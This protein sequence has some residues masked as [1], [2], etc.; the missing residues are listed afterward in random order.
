MT[1][2]EIIFF[3]SG[4]VLGAVIGWLATKD[5]Y[6]QRYQED[7]QAVKEA[8]RKDKGKEEEK[9]EIKEKDVIEGNFKDTKLLNDKEDIMKYAS[10]LVE[11]RYT[12]KKLEEMPTPTFIHVISPDDFGEEDDYDQVSLTYYSGDGTLADETGEAIDESIIGDALSHFGEYEDDSVFVRDDRKKV[13]YEV[14]LDHRSYS[15][16]KHPDVEG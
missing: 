7:V 6:E 8:L 16:I 4:G 5:R 1:N 15:E 12:S 3:V 10:K 11:N 9:E 13:D 14:L 2:R